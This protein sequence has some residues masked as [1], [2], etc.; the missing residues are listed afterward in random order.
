M[1]DWYVAFVGRSEG[2]SIGEAY[3]DGMGIGAFV[4]NWRL[5]EE[6]MRRGSRIEERFG[7]GAGSWRST[8]GL[9]VNVM[10]C[11]ANNII[12][13]GF[14]GGFIAG[15]SAHLISFGCVSFVSFGGFAAIVTGVAIHDI[16]VCPAVAC[17]FGCLLWSAVGLLHVGHFYLQ[18]FQFF[19]CFGQELGK[20]DL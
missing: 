3:A 16:S 10:H 1:K 19:G 11:V 13:P 15:R 4:L 17:E 18:C 12:P 9:Q 5:R 8:I 14:S 7:I 20:H 2:L 6:E